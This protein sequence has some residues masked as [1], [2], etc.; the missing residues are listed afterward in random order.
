V[1]N[2][3]QYLRISLLNSCNLNCTYCRPAQVENDKLISG[4][5]INYKNS[6]K[7]MLKLG[8]KKIRFTGGEPTLYK[9]LPEL[10]Q[11]VKELN[12]SI[13]TAITTNGILM[14]QRAKIL[15]DAG[16][17]SVNISID[18]LQKRK[19][20]S[21]TCKD[22]FEDVID[23]IK[24][25]IKELPKVKLNIVT[26]RN[27]NHQEVHQLIQF[28]NSLNV[29]I[30]FIEYMPTR[31]NSHNNDEY[32]SGN[33]LMKLLPY[34]FK[35]VQSD[36]SSA[37]KYY[38]SD[39]LSI[40]VGFIN[41]VSHSFCE[42]CNRIRLTSDGRLFGCLFSGASFNLFDT[43]KKGY[44]HTKSETETLIRNKKYSG[45]SLTTNNQS[46]FPS[47]VNMGG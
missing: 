17:D 21:I 41:P 27:F 35:H 10:I 15:A 13:Y 2:R 28:A 4:N 30:R 45:C 24:Y 5:F 32:M 33:N 19:F 3:I 40:N 6:I 25:S 43:L 38:T 26:I 9:K 14:K 7:F 39:D 47:F 22:K 46:K 20:Q 16:L 29:D 12:P 18:T 34:N 42:N 31:Y 37:A 1:I 8:V 36:K 44:N 11:F 23:G